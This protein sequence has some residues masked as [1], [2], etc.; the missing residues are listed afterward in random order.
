MNGVNDPVLA[1]FDQVSV[2]ATTTTVLDV[3][4]ANPT[5]PDSAGAGE[6]ITDLTITAIPVKPHLGTATITHGGTRITYDPSGC[7][8]RLRTASNTP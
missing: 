6:P 4:K 5:N 1:R 8:Y 3:F 7:A 2:K